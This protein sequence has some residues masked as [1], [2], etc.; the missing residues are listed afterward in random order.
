MTLRTCSKALGEAEVDRQETGS[1]HFCHEGQV[2]FET[3][4]WECYRIFA[5]V[6]QKSAFFQYSSSSQD[7][8]VL[9]R[10]FSRWSSLRWDSKDG[11]I[12]M[13]SAFASRVGR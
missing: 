11:H 7:P 9:E 10:S 5:G 2:G 4:V 13:K 8:P 12:D 3:L 1:M 6:F